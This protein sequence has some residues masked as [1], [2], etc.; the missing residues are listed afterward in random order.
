MNEVN[1]IPL[2]AQVPTQVPSE[3]VVF[4]ETHSDYVVYVDESGD[5][6]L[7]SVDKNY[8]IFV[9]AF[10]VFFK[11]HYASTVVPIVERFKFRHFGHD[12]VI[13]H[14]SDIRKEMEPFNIFPNREE[15]QK[16][17][18]ELT[19][20]I[21]GVNFILI[22]CIIDKRKIYPKP[23]QDLNPYHIALGTCLE[24]LQEL[25]IEKRQE[26]LKTHVVM[27]CRG[28]KEDAALELEFRR[29]CD[30][31]NRFGIPLSFSPVL[32][33]KKSNS[34]GLQLA[35][36]VARPIGRHILDVTQKNRAFDTLRPKFFC[37]GG[38]ANLGKDYVGLGLKIYPAQESEKP[39]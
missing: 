31:E 7:M 12:M 16:F 35:D 30:G 8:P 2:F 19:G 32:A 22:S 25:M 6:S 15:H 23:S 38:R 27:E 1:Q 26:K 24:A 21:D 20:I 4:K 39:R 5:H 28:K 11:A 34:A 18:E 36:L 13:L 29:I 17:T 10:C 33:D 9:L 37:R 3:R 14:E